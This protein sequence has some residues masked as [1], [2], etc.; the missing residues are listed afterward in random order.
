[1]D[2]CTWASI[3]NT[4][5]KR[6]GGQRNISSLDPR[7]GS[8]TWENSDNSVACHRATLEMMVAPSLDSAQDAARNPKISPAR[9][10]QKIKLPH[11]SVEQPWN[12]FC[13]QAIN[14]FVASN[15][16]NFALSH[17]RISQIRPDQS[18][19]PDWCF[20]GMKPREALNIHTPVP[21]DT[22]ADRSKVEYT[23]TIF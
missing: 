13:A 23:K 21:I 7:Q 14:V 17:H 2:H 6:I 12:K 16:L 5:N 1:M 15:R 22:V 18:T 19:S 3:A 20:R 9:H 10:A 8:E 11:L 4:V